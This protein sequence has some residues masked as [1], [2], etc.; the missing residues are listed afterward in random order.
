MQ[1]INDGWGETQQEEGVGIVIKKILF[2]K[3]LKKYFFIFL[4]LFFISTFLNLFFK[5]MKW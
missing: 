4:N 1:L 5:I 2:K 3:I